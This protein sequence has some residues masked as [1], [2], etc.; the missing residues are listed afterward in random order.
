MKK[1]NKIVHTIKFRLVFLISMI[2]VAMAIFSVVIAMPV[3]G[4]LNN[5][6]SKSYMKD[7]VETEKQIL[8]YKISSGGRESV[9]QDVLAYMYCDYHINDMKHSY[10]YIVDQ[11]GQIVYHPLKKYIGQKDTNK[12]I[13]NVAEQFKAGK[14]VPNKVTKFTENGVA[15]Y[16]SYEVVTNA[17]W[18]LV[19][20]VQEDEMTK[21]V[22]D[23]F[24][25]IVIGDII[26]VIVCVLVGIIIAGGIAKPI[27]R[28]TG[29][30]YDSS[31][32]NFRKNDELYKLASKNGESGQI[33]SAVCTLQNKVKSV[34]YDIQRQ[35]D[36][37]SSAASELDTNAKTT[38]ETIG[39]VEKAVNDI[40]QGA[41]SQAE[42]TQRA[43]QTVIAMGDLIKETTSRIEDLNLSSQSIKDSSNN[44][45]AV[46]E[47]LYN[48][49]QKAAEY[50]ETIY[51][52]T[53]VTNESAQKIKE[54]LSLIT[55]IADETNL[56]SLNA[57]IEAA[58][59]GEQGRGFAVVASQIQKL[60]E[61]SNNSAQSIDLIIESLLQDS[62]SAVNTMNQ[63]KNIMEEQSK[64]VKETGVIFNVVKEGVD[65]SINSIGEISEKTDKMDKARVSV[66]DVV[67]ELTAI[68]EENAAS[69]E[70][71]SAYTAQVNAVI[72]DI[73][74]KTEVLN[75][76]VGKLE[77]QINQFQV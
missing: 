46:L 8:N 32:L 58:R 42:E 49:N 39:Q 10:I 76:I 55:S 66:V 77:E 11:E 21:P 65:Q 9:T 5:S 64:K 19:L 56:L 38:Q 4:N 57:S 13:L 43:T 6:I 20:S 60:A 28:L 69:T 51:K 24:K 7:V 53:N 30:I 25:R 74:Q 41:T 3:I 47:G 1:K 63:V 16:V 15:K 22:R 34:I 2:V 18:V 29:I 23:I 37:L 45:V 12:T 27:K 52:Q 17:K 73:A 50:I 40:A 35:T 67:Q 70:E 26:A 61:Q 68:A 75:E 36:T 33:S 71:T 31:Q 62:A 14:T 54:A 59:A 48:T 72:A 44:A